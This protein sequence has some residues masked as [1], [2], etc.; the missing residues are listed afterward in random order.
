VARQGP[1]PVNKEDNFRKS[2]AY[3]NEG[4]GIL[5]PK[6]QDIAHD[7]LKEQLPQ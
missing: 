4:D 1:E 5:V 7:P 3:N 6:T 2:D